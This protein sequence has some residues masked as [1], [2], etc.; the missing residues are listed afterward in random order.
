MYLHI[1]P[2]LFH[3]MANKCTLKSIS[4]PELDFIIDSES[5]SVGRPWPNKCL[6]VGMRKGRKS[7]NGLVLQTDKKL[8]WFTTI[9]T[10]DIEDMGL[11]YHQVNTY[12]EDDDFDMV[13]Q[14]ILLNGS[15]DKWSY[16][17]HSAYENK[18]P[19][20]IQPKMES[21]LNKPGENSHDVWEEFEWGDFLLSREES[22][23]LH[24]IQSERLSTDC[25]LFK[26][27]PSIESALVI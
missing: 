15:F 12:I 20:R 17:V 22:L 25:S 16:R 10:W 3:R 5:L 6:W 18:P 1:V 7:V 21:L 8:R 2:K 27:Q 11:I 19:A 4:I 24:T 26:R 9:Y 14:E 13:S 23:L